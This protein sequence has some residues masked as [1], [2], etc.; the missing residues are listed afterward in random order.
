MIESLTEV[1]TYLKDL[2]GHVT[3][4]YN[5]RHCG[6]EPLWKNEFEMW[7]GNDYIVVKNID[8]V[9]NKPFFNGKTLN[10]IWSDVINIDY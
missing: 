4:D 1:R 3:F 5:G 2:V 10:D 8:D 6:V 9:F 7:Y